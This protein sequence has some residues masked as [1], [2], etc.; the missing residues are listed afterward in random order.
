ML[1]YD[2]IKIVGGV[3]DNPGL[4]TKATG[5]VIDKWEKVSTAILNK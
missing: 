2:H 3:L 1:V 5:N 4:V